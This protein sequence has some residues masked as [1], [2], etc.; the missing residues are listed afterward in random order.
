MEK[1]RQVVKGEIELRVRVKQLV[2]DYADLINYRVM[3]LPFHT[4]LAHGVQHPTVLRISY[5]I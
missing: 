1:K 2:K 4:A 3:S 5:N